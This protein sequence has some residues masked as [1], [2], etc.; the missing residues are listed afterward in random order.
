MP[1]DFRVG[2]EAGKL[3][4]MLR[5]VSLTFEQPTQRSIERS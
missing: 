1:H 2:E 4:Q 3:D 5:R